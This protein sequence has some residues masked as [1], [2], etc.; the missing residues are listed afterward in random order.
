MSSPLAVPAPLAG[1]IWDGDAGRAW[2]QE[3]DLWHFGV[4]SVQII[5]H[6]ELRALGSSGPEACGH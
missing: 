4:V 5:S 2:G 3:W 6:L 1:S